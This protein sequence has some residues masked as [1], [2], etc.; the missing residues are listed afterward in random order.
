MMK[1]ADKIGQEALKFTRL[2]T[3]SL[4]YLDTEQIPT[5]PVR[6]SKGVDMRIL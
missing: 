3:H 4:K 5:S 2:R 6:L 1:S